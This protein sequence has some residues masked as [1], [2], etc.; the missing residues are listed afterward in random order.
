MDAQATQSVPERDNLALT[1]ETTPDPP[2]AE[3]R[4]AQEMAS[5]VGNLWNDLAAVSIDLDA[6]SERIASHVE[7]FGELRMAAETMVQTNADI[8]H[9]AHDADDLARQVMSEAEESQSSLGEAITDIQELVDSVRRIEQFLGGLSTALQRVSNVSE[10]IDA[11]AR[12]TRLLALNATIEAARAGAAGKGFGVVAGEVKAL[13]Q[14]TS[15]ATAHISETVGELSRII[16]S[17]NGESRGSID[18]AAHVQTSTQALGDVLHTLGGQ[19]GQMGHRIATI[20]S[21]AQENEESC[22]SVVEAL[23]AITREV[24]RES[25]DLREANQR[26]NRVMNDTQGVVES[27]M[28]GGFR[29]PDSV[30]LDI[31]RE[32]AQ[33]VTDVFLAALERGVLTEGDL[34]DEAYTPIP[35]SNPQQVMTRFTAF[36]DRS[37][38]GIQEELVTRNDKILFCAAVD[39]NGYLPTHNRKYSHPQRPDDPVWNAANCRNRRIFDDPTGLAAGR[40]TAPFKLTSYRRDMGGGTFV[41][42]KDLSAPIFI[43]DR[44]WGGFRMGYLL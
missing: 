24:E 10:E 37:L 12:Q 11:I 29:T 25:T 34:F 3:T 44:H 32:G 6:V 1:P 23:T 39:R 7:K 22:R 13:S 43:K 18:R 17:L 27:A 20:T 35:G 4:R 31:V 5:T 41:L 15:N 36:T 19:I 30:F 14:Q 9:A 26:T 8:G 40:N 2:G 38:P 33:R 42:C 16:D 28:L 21:E